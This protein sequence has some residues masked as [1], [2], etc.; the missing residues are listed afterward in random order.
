MLAA[1]RDFLKCSTL[2]KKKKKEQKKISKTVIMEFRRSGSDAVDL[3]CY[4][5]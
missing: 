5:V 2:T 1:L 4:D 3:L